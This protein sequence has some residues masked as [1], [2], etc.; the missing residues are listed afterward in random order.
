[1]FCKTMLRAM[2]VLMQMIVTY[3]YALLAQKSQ[4]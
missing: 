1:M 2:V 3:G 4:H